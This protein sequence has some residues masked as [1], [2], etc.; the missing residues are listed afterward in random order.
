MIFDS[1][2]VVEGSG[3][4]GVAVQKTLT[5]PGSIQQLAGKVKWNPGVA[6]Q[7]KSIVCSLGTAGS[8]E[9]KINVRVNGVVVSSVAIAASAVMSQLSVDIA[10]MTTDSVTVDVVSGGAGATDLTVHFNCFT[11]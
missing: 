9:T 5:Q 2:H 11:R 6:L 1:L 10:L 7:C 3:T 4:V 8:S